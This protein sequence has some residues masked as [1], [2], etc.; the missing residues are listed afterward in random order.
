MSTT[1]VIFEQR[2]GFHLTACNRNFQHS[3]D[4]DIEMH[5]IR[6]LRPPSLSH[7]RPNVSIVSVSVTITTDLGD[8][9]LN[10]DAPI[11][12]K[13]GIYEAAADR[14]GRKPGP[15]DIKASQILEWRPGTRALKLDLTL[16]KTPAPLRVFIFPTA[17][18]WAGSTQDVVS[19]LSHADS[20]RIMPVWA[21]VHSPGEDSTHVSIRRLRVGTEDSP[22]CLELEEEIGE[23]I[24][25]HI[26]DAGL[27]AAS[28]LVDSQPASIPDS[29]LPRL[30]QRLASDQPLNVLEL[31][32]GVGILGLAVASALAES[33]RLKSLVLL[34][35]L[36]DARE[37]ALANISRRSMLYPG[38]TTCPT[39]FESL[40]WEEGRQ[41]TFGPLVRSRSWPLVVLSDCTYNVDMLPAL[42]GTLSALHE[43]N[44]ARQDV[45]ASSQATWVLLATKP[46]H[47][48]E[49]ALHGLMAHQGWSVLEKAVLPLPVISQETEAVEL[50]VF[51]R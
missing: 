40:D 45:V 38:R 6:F 8:S 25:R 2:P 36:P 39:E 48:S 14:D 21:D 49:E 35:D 12:L 15:P 23:S 10:P 17:Q 3:P 50:Y 37:R 30:R 43:A 46:R 11:K 31:G 22:S 32:C 51:E 20:G 26:W 9:F 1:A 41:G 4:Y 16:P 28:I 29:L 24:A 34:T 33:A 5:Y 18:L 42:V 7:N 47:S 19:S 44:T 27:V 13:A